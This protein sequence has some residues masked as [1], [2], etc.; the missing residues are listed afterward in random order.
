ML[1]TFLSELDPRIKLAIAIA[2]LAAAYVISDYYLLTVGLVVLAIS[3]AQL[4]LAKLS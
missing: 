4:V 2:L 1:R 3:V